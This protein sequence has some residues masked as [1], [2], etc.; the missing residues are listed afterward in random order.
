VGGG[1]HAECFSLQWS[2]SSRARRKLKA[3]TDES[4]A[5]NEWSGLLTEAQPPPPPTCAHAKGSGRRGSA[6]GERKVPRAGGRAGG[7]EGTRVL[8][9]GWRA[10]G[11]MRKSDAPSVG[12]PCDRAPRV[13]AALHVQ[14]TRP[15]ARVVFAWWKFQRAQRAFSVFNGWIPLECGRVRRTRSGSHTPPPRRRRRRR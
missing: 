7:R 8:K 15:P 1:P 13:G 3:E 6:G 10:G 11:R 14:G 4:P 9:A 2:A 12:R 5:V